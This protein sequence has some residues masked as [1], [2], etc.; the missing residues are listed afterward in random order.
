[1]EGGVPGLTPVG[2]QTPMSRLMPGALPGS[3]AGPT[4][5]TM[6]Q[7][8][9]QYNEADEHRKA[10]LEQVQTFKKQVK[11]REGSLL[12]ASH[13]IEESS[14][15]LKRTREEFRQWE[16]EMQ[17]LRERVRKLEENR[18]SVGVLIEEILQHLDRPKDPLK[19]PGI[20]HPVK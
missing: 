4:N 14:T 17:E 11:E 2:P 10:L 3:P 16:T 12:L 20:F 13:E 18:R 9:K 1:M 19:L 5:E 7:L 8:I 15:K 6:M